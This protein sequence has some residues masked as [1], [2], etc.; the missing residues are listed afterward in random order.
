MRPVFIKIFRISERLL[1][2]RHLSQ[3]K[4]EYITLFVNMK[5]K[6]TIHI[7]DGKRGETV[8]DFAEHLEAMNGSCNAVTN[9]SYDM[10]PAFVKK[11]RQI[12]P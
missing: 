9:A 4:H 5:K 3:K 10:S 2:T 8:E 12:S 7:N 6:K 1:L 11:G